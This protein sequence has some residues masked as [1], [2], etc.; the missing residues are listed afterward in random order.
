[1]LG[2]Q[3]LNKRDCRDPNTSGQLR[4]PELR[5]S[6]TGTPTPISTSST[7]APLASAADPTIFAT[8]G[9]FSGDAGHEVPTSDSA[10]SDPGKSSI[11]SKSDFISIGR[12]PILSL[13]FDFVGLEGCSALL[14]KCSSNASMALLMRSLFGDVSHLTQ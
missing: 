7:A 8:L 9:P 12:L 14:I 13:L 1:M 4:L 5:R 3:R 11:G 2:P 6:L 10:P